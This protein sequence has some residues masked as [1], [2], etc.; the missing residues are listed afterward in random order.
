M[1][2]HV[3]PFRKDIYDLV[4]EPSKKTLSDY[5]ISKG[6]TIVKDKETFD[7]DIVSTKDGFTYFNEVEVKSS[8]KDEWPEH[9]A[10]IR[11]PGR[12]RRL[13][14]KYKDQNGVLNF[15]VLNKFMDK[16]WRIKDTLMTDDTLKVAVGRRI[17]KGETFF[18][19]PYQEAEFI[20]L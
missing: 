1:Q 12:K 15:Y 3:R 11:I 9:W 16:A 6:H 2:V 14:E 17:P 7:A 13:V 10:E 20:N 19:I 18:H 8:W 5:L 4:D